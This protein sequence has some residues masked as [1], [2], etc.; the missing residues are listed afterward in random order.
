M[1]RITSSEIVSLKIY[2]GSISGL[3]DS[4]DSHIC[5]SEF[6]SCK[7]VY[8]LLNLLMFPGIEN[9]IAR[10]CKERKE[11]PVKLLENLEDIITIYRDIFS[12]MFKFP[13]I[14]KLNN[15]EALHIY[16]K[17]RM[18]SM[19]MVNAGYTY[20][21]TS[22]SF[23]DDVGQFFKDKDGLLLLECDILSSIPHVVLNEVLGEN[24]YQSQEEVL[25]PPFLKFRKK[26]M[27]YTSKELK[28]RDKNDEPPKAKYLLEI[29]EILPL[30]CVDME[31]MIASPFYPE[32]MSAVKADIQKLVFDDSEVHHAIKVLDSFY[33]G[34][35][36]TED[37][38]R[39]CRW[40]KAFRSLVKLEFDE[41]RRL[42]TI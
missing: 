23:L 14:S 41:I 6:L 27:P 32:N 15:M 39:Y 8:Q 31:M 25:L 37:C 1:Y 26:K 35:A 2:Q 10:I 24:K 20:S 40:K 33:D 19:Q 3:S 11:I 36:K 22:C 29:E 17:D 13:H 34:Q 30:G 38:C 12:I 9:E 18:Q 16:R 5:L 7:G 28:Y 42:Y 21:F 4:E